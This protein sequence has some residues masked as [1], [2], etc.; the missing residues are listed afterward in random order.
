MARKLNIW[1][2]RNLTLV[3][4]VLIS[5]S[6]RISNLVYSLNSVNTR[7][8]DIVQTQGTVYKFIWSRKPSKIK[9]TTLR[10]DYNKA[11]LQLPDLITMRQ[12]MRSAWIG[13]LWIARKLN[14]IISNYLTRYGG[15]KLLLHSNYNTTYISTRILQRTFNLFSGA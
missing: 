15:I 5:K 7:E 8:K 10:G 6:I 4:K 3:G 11:G 2:Q 9:H 12:S 1:S 13:R 14:E